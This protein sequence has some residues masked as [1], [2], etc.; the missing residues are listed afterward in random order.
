MLS[1]CTYGDYSPSQD[2]DTDQLTQQVADLQDTI[3]SIKM[4][5]WFCGVPLLMLIFFGDFG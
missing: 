1:G 2:S 4:F 3:Q 5:A